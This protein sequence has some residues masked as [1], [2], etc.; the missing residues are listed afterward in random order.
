MPGFMQM[1]QGPGQGQGMGGFLGG[2]PTGLPGAGGGLGGLAEMLKQ[3]QMVQQYLAEALK[4]PM[5]KQ[6][7]GGPGM[8]QGPGNLAPQL[9]QIPDAI[10]GQYGPTG[11]N[12]S[13]PQRFGPGQAGIDEGQ[14]Q[15]DVQGDKYSRMEDV[16]REQLPMQEQEIGNDGSPAAARLAAKPRPKQEAVN[17][18]MQEIDYWMGQPDSPEKEQRIQELQ[19]QL[20]ELQGSPE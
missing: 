2:Q 5:T 12:A 11:G 17:E 16:S 10:P 3:Q 7:M 18:M 4:T 8:Q 20:Q 19:M 6:G 15:R 9:P 1:P 14:T 13:P